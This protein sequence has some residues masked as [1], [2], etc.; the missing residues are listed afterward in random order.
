[1]RYL[2]IILFIGGIAPFNAAVAQG[3]TVDLVFG[4]VT[5]A[6]NSQGEVVMSV[7]LPAIDLVKNDSAGVVTLGI[8]AVFSDPIST[9]I[10]RRVEIYGITAYPNPVSDH[11]VIQKDGTHGE[12]LV[13]IVSFDGRT[14][15]NTLWPE[16]DSRL[17]IETG[18]LPSGVYAVSIRDLTTGRIGSITLSKI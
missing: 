7:G 15:L 11:V 12:Y 9:G 10:Y 17:T 2:I 5:Y 18:D 1:M 16:A 8:P 13:S 6:S 4:Q 3:G 14:V